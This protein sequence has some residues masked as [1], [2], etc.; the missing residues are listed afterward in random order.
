MIFI[1][2]YILMYILKKYSYETILT[3]KHTFIIKYFSF[4]SLNVGLI[5]IKPHL[6]LD[7]YILLREHKRYNRK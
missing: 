2:V 4:V 3:V 6:H 7:N 5:I 1:H